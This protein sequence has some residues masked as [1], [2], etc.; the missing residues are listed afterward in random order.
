MGAFSIW[1]YLILGII[2]FLL[3]SPIKKIINKTKTD[4]K[5]LPT[6]T[7]KDHRI[8]L[9]IVLVFIFGGYF[10]MDNIA[11]KKQQKKEELMNLICG[12]ATTLQ[13]IVCRKLQKE[14]EKK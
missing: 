3:Y 4:N 10:V 12:K 2:I 8:W 14:K 5:N 6:E 7:K 9:L 1:H 13:G 11:N